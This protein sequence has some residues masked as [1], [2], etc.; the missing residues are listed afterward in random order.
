M[1]APPL[2]RRSEAHHSLA[3][4]RQQLVDLNDTIRRHLGQK[5][6]SMGEHEHECTPSP[7]ALKVPLIAQ[8]EAVADLRRRVGSHL[9]LWGLPSLCD[10]AQLCVSEMVT[11]VLVHVGEGTPVTLYMAMTGPC[12]RIE[13]TDPDP[14]TLPALL[15]TVDDDESGRGLALIDAVA[16]RWGVLQQAG[17]KTVWC[18]LD[19]ESAATATATATAKTRG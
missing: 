1:A 7:G 16:A 6:D 8:P 15:G 19:A 12:P 9:V 2:R 13:L 18:E 5:W 3:E 11:N 14:R 4:L 10:A 17:S